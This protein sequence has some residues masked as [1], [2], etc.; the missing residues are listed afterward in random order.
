MDENTRVLREEL[1]SGSRIGISELEHEIERERWRDRKEVVKVIATSFRFLR[2]LYE[3]TE[4]SRGDREERK[5]GEG[6]KDLN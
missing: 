3:L 5:D 4:L 6:I 1:L 2:I